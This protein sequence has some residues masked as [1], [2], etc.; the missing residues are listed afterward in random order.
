MTTINNSSP[1]II[2]RKTGEMVISAIKHISHFLANLLSIKNTASPLHKAE[3]PRFHHDSTPPPIS[4][5]ERHFNSGAITIEHLPVLTPIL[6]ICTTPPI[7][8][9]FE[10]PTEMKEMLRGYKLTSELAEGLKL[11]LIDFKKNKQEKLQPNQE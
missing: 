6:P 4:P 10:I 9:S 8:Q 1:I 11:A 7:P 2:I 3:I 5:L